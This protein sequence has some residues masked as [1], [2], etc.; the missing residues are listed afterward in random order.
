MR[1]EKY[2]KDN[3]LKPTPWAVKHRIAAAVISR[4]LNGKGI[5]PQNAEKIEVA[6]DGDVSVMELLYP[7]RKKAA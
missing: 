6:T 3:K 4:Y 2:L 7:D 5:S 1:L